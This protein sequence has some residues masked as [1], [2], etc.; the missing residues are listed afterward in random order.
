MFKYKYTVVVVITLAVL[1]TVF[2]IS[3][4]AG[5]FLPTEFPA[6]KFE[7][8]ADRTCLTQCGNV[9]GFPPY[10]QFSQ[11]VQATDVDGTTWYY[12]CPHGTNFNIAGEKCVVSK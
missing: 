2:I 7:P 9:P 8:A 12:C 11:P 3:R 5:F 4:Q 10:T 6:C 1:G